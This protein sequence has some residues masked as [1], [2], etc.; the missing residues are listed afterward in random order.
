MYYRPDKGLKE[1]QQLLR[2]LLAKVGMHGV[3]PEDR[4]SDCIK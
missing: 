1:S 3:G 4:T 2:K